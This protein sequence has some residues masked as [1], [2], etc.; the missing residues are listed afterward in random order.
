MK[1][2]TA[3]AVGLLVRVAILLMCGAIAPVPVLVTGGMYLVVRFNSHWRFRGWFRVIVMACAGLLVLGAFGLFGA[4]QCAS[5]LGDAVMASMMALAVF[6]DGPVRDLPEARP[7]NEK[8]ADY[9]DVEVINDGNARFTPQKSSR[10]GVKRS[11]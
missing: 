11:G 5:L 3:D 1:T 9:I 8:V 10:R 6:W 7:V 2:G 4:V